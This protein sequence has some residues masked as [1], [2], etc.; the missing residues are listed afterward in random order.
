MTT[1]PPNLAGRPSWRATPSPGGWSAPFWSTTAVLVVVLLA[2]GGAPQP[3]PVGLPDA[4]PVTGWGLPLVRLAADLL[5]IA[6]LGLLLAAAFLL[7]SPAA[8]LADL[9]ARAAIWAGRAATAWLAAV[10]VEVVLT[11]LGHPR[12]AARHGARAD[13]AAQLPGPDLAGSRR[14]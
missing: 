13:A 6:T 3:V 12:D 5:G 7:P 1:A 4:G 9:P 8:G 14:C 2:G 11:A 10:A